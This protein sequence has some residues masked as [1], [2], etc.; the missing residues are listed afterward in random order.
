MT[1][2]VQPTTGFLYKFENSYALAKDI[3]IGFG[4]GVKITNYLDGSSLFNNNNSI[5][6]GGK[7]SK[8]IVAIAYENGGFTEEKQVDLWFIDRVR[9]MV[10]LSAAYEF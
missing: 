8:V 6:M 9:Q 4:L 1:Q 2:E 3:H 10:T 7:I 5:F